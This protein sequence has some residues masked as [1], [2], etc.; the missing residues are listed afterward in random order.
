MTAVLGALLDGREG[1]QVHGFGLEMGLL[2][3]YSLHLSKFDYAYVFMVWK[4]EDAVKAFDEISEPDIVSWSERIFAA[5]D[6]VE[7][8]EVFK[9]LHSRGMVVNEFTVINLQ[10]QII[11]VTF[12]NLGKQIH[13]LYFKRGHTQL[14]SAGNA[15]IS[16]CGK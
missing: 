4:P 16:L 12:L 15:L 13:A 3:G 5:C 11:D 7:A 6:G 10:S 2:S 9:L 1:G 14:V 8:S